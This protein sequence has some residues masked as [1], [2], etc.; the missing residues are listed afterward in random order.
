MRGGRVV[1]DEMHQRHLAQADRHI[2]MGLAIISKQ[3]ALMDGLERSG[4]DSTEARD[5]LTLFEE[6]LRLMQEHRKMILLAL[7]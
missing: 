5:L 1:G 3:T 2:A 6:A 7:R 4:Q